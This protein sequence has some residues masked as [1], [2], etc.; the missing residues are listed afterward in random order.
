M[1]SQ[2]SSVKLSSLLSVITISIVFVSVFVLSGAFSSIVTTISK[3]KASQAN[4]KLTEGFSD[5]FKDENVNADK[6][7]KAASTGVTVGETAGN[8]LRINIPAGNQDNKAKAGSLTFNELF[9]DKGDFRVVAV[10]YRP[11]VT[12]EG[13]G[14]S[15]IRF[16]SQGEDNDEGVALQWVV[17]GTNSTAS[18]IVRGKD[19]KKL[20]S[21]QKQLVSNVAVLRLE[22]IN[23]RYRAYVKPG[24]D[25]SGDTGW[26]QLGAESD[27]QL[28]EQGRV[29]LFTNNAGIAGKFPQVVGRF[30]QAA[31]RWEG[32]PSQTSAINDSFA[33]GV[34]AQSWNVARAD[35]TMIYENANDN[36]IMSMPS[37]ALNNKTRYAFLNRINP[38][39]AQGKGFSLRA[40]MYKPTVVG[41][42]IG[43]VGL[44]FVSAGNV[45]DEAA[46]VRWVVG[47]GTSKVVFSVR[48]TDGTV[49]ETASANLDANIKQ[50]TIGLTRSGN[51]YKGSYRRGDND[52]D[53]VEIGAKE[54]A[55]L[56]AGGVVGLMVSNT[57]TAGKYPRV[58]GRIDQV[59]GSV[60][61]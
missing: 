13:A 58:V 59:A 17:N 35:G 26:V 44:R 10:V 8:N 46:S 25:T 19:G 45:D 54:G 32:A 14:V 36:L 22:R 2:K 3:S 53:W 27:A 11:I 21:E 39:I 30:D 29:R 38:T 9:P 23:K 33:N 34:L 52:T 60:S 6:W 20:D 57:G 28:G 51:Q 37:G 40:R 55:T 5:A 50:L 43:Y 41:D 47:N 42:G 7:T 16:T 24:A 56:G 61:N 4:P 1:A 12:G 15:G 18:F 48:N 49:L 31:I